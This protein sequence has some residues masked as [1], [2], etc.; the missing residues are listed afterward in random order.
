[1]A[2]LSWKGPK[3]KAS[4][5]SRFKKSM[6]RKFKFLPSL[7]YAWVG[8]GNL[9][10]LSPLRTQPIGVE[11]PSSLVLASLLW[12]PILLP[13]VNLSSLMFTAF[14]SPCGSSVFIAT[15]LTTIWIPSTKSNSIF[16]TQAVLGGFWGSTET[17][18]KCL[19]LF[20]IS[21]AT[22]VVSCVHMLV[23]RKAPSPLMQSGVRLIVRFCPPKMMLL[24]MVITLLLRFIGTFKFKIHQ[25]RF[26]HTRKTIELD[27][28]KPSSPWS[29]VASGSHQWN[30]SLSDVNSA[31]ELWA[32]DTE[33]W[34]T[35][36]G[37]VQD[38]QPERNLGSLPKV[39]TSTHRLA[40]T[41][42]LEERVLRRWI[43]RLKEA[44][45]CGWK[46]ASP[47]ES[48]LRKIYKFHAPQNE[49]E[50]V[51]QHAWGTAVKLAESRLQSLLQVKSR[52]A[53]DKWR[54]RV[55][56]FPGAC[57]WVKLEEAA[58]P[59]L[60]T[61]DGQILSCR[62]SAL[63]ALRDYWANI[64]GCS[65]PACSWTVFHDTFQP[66]LP[67]TQPSPQLPDI[68]INDIQ[69]CLKRMKGKAGGPDGFTPD[70]IRVL[71]TPALERL[72]QL[73]KIFETHGSWPGPLREWRVVFLPKPKPAG[74]IVRA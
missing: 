51:Q 7:K 17:Q 52:L 69:N 68:T 47:S 24:A 65:A 40:P 58:S 12:R 9:C 72:C 35:A 56:T 63:K 4:M 11:L 22:M 73:L 5:F 39:K 60:Q 57:K 42:S 14:K 20:M 38:S 59:V 70:L 8:V 29:C 46:G 15:T 36:N 23:V 3:T 66:H 49:A 27:P 74:V 1:M 48:L 25:F 10:G 71:S 21:L 16:S 26:T 41:Q 67:P 30:Q 18:I 45:T 62:T 31:W 19:V 44:H 34:L 32:K 2:C 28:K 61:D 37:Y 53:L 64:F 43:R 50:A 13:R 6:S 54:Q 33:A 55:K